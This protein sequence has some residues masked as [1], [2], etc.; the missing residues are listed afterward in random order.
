MGILTTGRW[1]L[2]V[3]LIFIPL[4]LS[5]IDNFYICVCVFKAVWVKVTYWNWLFTS[6]PGE[7]LCSF[8]PQPFFESKSYL[9][10][11]HLMNHIYPRTLLKGRSHL[12]KPTGLLRSKCPSELVQ[13][14]FSKTWP[15]GGG[16]SSFPEH[17]ASLVAQLVKNLPAVWDTWVRSWVVKIPW[18]RERLPL[19]YSGLEN[20]LNCVV[21]GLAE[22]DVIERLSQKSTESLSGGLSCCCL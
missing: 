19:Q 16:I 3:F 10:A 22:L 20:S 2:S 6:C 21:H 15:Q 13:V 5:D 8:L 17:Q 4:I 14:E 12:Y 1:Y 18:R 11:H 7:F 9:Q